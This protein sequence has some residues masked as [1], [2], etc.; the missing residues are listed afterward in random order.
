MGEGGMATVYLAQDLKHK[1]KVAIKVLKPELAAVVGAECFLAE[2]ETTANLQHP[3]ILP[4]FD[5]GQAGSFLFYVMP[6][7][8]G[9]TL[10]E[11]LQRESQL[12]VDEA[13]RIATAVAN[14]LQA[15]HERGVVHRDIKPGNILLSRGEPLVADFGIALA[16]GAAGG[17]RLT[18]TGLSLGTPFYMSPEQATGDQF[19][20]PAT[21][22]YAL[23]C[24]LYEMLVGEPPYLGNTA[25][26]V[27]GKILQGTPVSATAV[28]KS[29]PAHVDAA[30]RRGLEKLPA[31]RFANVQDFSRAL[32]DPS[33]RHGEPAGA[34]AAAVHGLWS[35]LTLG[36]AAIAALSLSAAAWIATRPEAPRVPM[37]VSVLL[38]EGEDFAGFGSFALSPDGTFM[39]YEGPREGGGPQ[40]WVKRWDRLKGEPLP[41]AET[42]ILPSVSPDGSRVAYQSGGFPTR[43]IRLA[44]LTG[45]PSRVVVD[46]AWCCVTWGGPDTLY[47]SDATRGLSKVAATGGAVVSVRPIS[48][49][50]MWTPRIF[51]D[52]RRAVESL[53]QD[54][55]GWVAGLNLE[56]GET[57]RLVEGHD[58]TV[59]STGHLLFV[60]GDRTLMAAPFDPEGLRVTG[61]AVAM[62]QDL[63]DSGDNIGHYGVSDATGMLVYRTRPF[64]GS[65]SQLLRQNGPVSE[66]VDPTW[67]T[68]VSVNGGG[69]ALSPRGDQIAVTVQDADGQADVYV[70]GYP[71]GPAYRLSL[72][73]ADDVGPS[74]SPDGRHVVFLS[75]R[76]GKPRVYRRR[77]DGSAATELLFEE[78]RPIV[79]SQ[80]S[81]DGNW[82]V[83]ATTV[84]GAGNGDI[85]G[86]RL[87]IDSVPRA[88]VATD[89]PEGEPALSPDGRWLAYVSGESGR[90]EVF[91][92]PFPN[93]EESR[94]PVS[95]RGG[96]APRW[97]RTGHDLY[98]EQ[99]DAYEDKVLVRTRLTFEPRFGAAESLAVS[100]SRY[101]VNYAADFAEYDVL[102]EG[103]GIITMTP[104]GSDRP[105]ELIVVQDFYE[106]LRRLVG[107]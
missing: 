31:D 95:S 99:G 83:Y 73:P 19:V 26:A 47:F 107:G 12:P 45:G 28:R 37:E 81:N 93:V 27:L 85:M 1:R 17:G 94:F 18:E 8:E 5:S 103:E 46:S 84:G 36:L 100:D 34:A 87:G 3:H 75:D 51:L 6:Y 52:G 61:P 44:S 33:F 10:R 68:R 24:V 82:L 70:K 42:G 59:T 89:V 7:V 67:S 88:L 2:I 72:S 58:P 25:Q 29:I 98:Y 30:V 48:E 35:P 77:A 79:R 38:P 76:D 4:L 57:V 54:G 80:L 56:T 63:R 101:A 15:A 65:G 104:E 50:N 69:I 14:A 11:R 16:V 92:R 90:S 97:S 60:T 106:R 32:K 96:R 64:A 40:L 49:G 43:Q 23:A 66:I 41:G 62:A 22:I 105:I 102:P 20:G 21:D 74:W 71:E 39:V 53:F 86:I 91:V 9:E 13:V 78:E 55:K